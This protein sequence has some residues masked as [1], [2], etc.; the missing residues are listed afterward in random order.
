MYWLTPA[1][2]EAA[3]AYARLMITLHTAETRDAIRI[4][5]AISESLRALYANRPN[6]FGAKE[7]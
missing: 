3:R 7:Q 4:E 2:H 5:R 1:D 6:R